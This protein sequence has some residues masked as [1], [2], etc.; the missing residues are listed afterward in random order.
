VGFS[1]NKFEQH[2]KQAW[3]WCLIL[4]RLP[5]PPWNLITCFNAELNKSFIQLYNSESVSETTR[6]DMGVTNAKV[7]ELAIVI[8]HTENN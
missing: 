6:T 8:Q 5:P 3:A 7:N 1:G 2:D 4:G